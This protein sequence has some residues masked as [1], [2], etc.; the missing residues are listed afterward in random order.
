M[1]ENR[2]AA[3]WLCKV[4]LFKFANTEISFPGS[5]YFDY[6]NRFVLSATMDA[7]VL[8]NYKNAVTTIVGQIGCNNITLLNVIV[9]H[10]SSYLINSKVDVLFLPSEVLIGEQYEEDIVINHIE[11]TMSQLDAFLSFK[12]DMDKVYDADR[13]LC[14]DFE[15][16]P[17]M[18]GIDSKGVIKI[19]ST[20]GVTNSTFGP[21]FKKVNV[22]S[23][24]YLAEG[25]LQ[26][27][28]KKIA[29]CRNMLSF[30][31]DYYLEVDDF[32][33][34]DK[35]G[36]QCKLFLNCNDEI[37]LHSDPFIIRINSIESNFEKIWNGWLTL[38]G[39]NSYIIDLFYEIVTD[40]SKRINLFLNL[41]QAIEV[42]SKRNRE[43][44]AKQA[45]HLFVNLGKISDCVNLEHRLFDIIKYTNVCH[46]VEDN[47]I[48]TISEKIRDA[49][50][51]FTHYDKKYIEPNYDFIISFGRLLRVTSLRLVYKEIGLDK[52]DGAFYVPNYE[53]HINAIVTEIRDTNSCT[54]E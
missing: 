53:Y 45:K 29:S 54:S 27:G 20:I 33:I 16:M 51:Y 49:R 2:E 8:R 48:K 43:K 13:H 12:I 3:D 50:N 5:V 10:S 34:V 28:I 23:Y 19:Y 39:N 11:T 24:D 18:E 42:Y 30:F 38:S 44:E 7:D 46:N 6:T 9:L 25:T 4:G 36:K 15:K 17:F 22:I 1:R 31:A 52:I 14:I 35:N 37:P 32:L 26:A 40:N 41:C 47:I 21:S